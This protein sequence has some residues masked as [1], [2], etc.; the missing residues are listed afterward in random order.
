MIEE[1]ASFFDD[2]FGCVEGT[3]E[4]AVCHAKSRKWATWIIL[5]VIILILLIVVPKLYRLIKGK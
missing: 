5:I 1:I 2:L 3:A 4:Y